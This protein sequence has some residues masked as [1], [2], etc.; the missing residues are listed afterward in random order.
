MDWKNDWE[1]R[2]VQMQLDAG[3]ACA[4]LE[5]ILYLFQPPKESDVF[6]ETEEKISPLIDWLRDEAPWK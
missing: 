1:Q 3:L 2:A 6:L 5:H 4:Y